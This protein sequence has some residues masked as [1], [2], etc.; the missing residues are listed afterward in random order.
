MIVIHYTAQ[1]SLQ[2]GL[3]TFKPATIF[4]DRPVLPRFGD[5]NVG[6]HFII[7]K[8]EEASEEAGN[9]AEGSYTERSS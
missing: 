1:H 2:A 9:Q 6:V 5:L 4:M 3:Y 8:K 7:N